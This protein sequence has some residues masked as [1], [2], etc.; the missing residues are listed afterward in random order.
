MRDVLAAWLRDSGHVRWAL[1][2][3]GVALVLGAAGFGVSA[4]NRT[5]ESRGRLALAAAVDLAQQASGPT[6]P[7]D[8]RERANRALEGVLAEHPRFSGAPEAAYRLGNLRY[9]AGQYP[10]ARGAYEIALGKGATGTLRGL[11]AL[12]IAYTFEAGKDYAR[13]QAAFQAALSGLSARDFLFEEML[14]GLARTQEFGG[15]PGA[16][17]ETYARLL[18]ERP[19]TRRADDI[20]SRLASLS[21][22]AK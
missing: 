20:R 6:A 13:A 18:K 22:P 10:A 1:A 4:W 12:G 19:E 9:E 15:N 11:A 5:Q 7:A 14:L 17:R 16:A 8:A 2:G 3:L 21:Q